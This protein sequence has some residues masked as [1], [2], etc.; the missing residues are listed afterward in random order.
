MTADDEAIALRDRVAR[1]LRAVPGCFHSELS[2]AGVP[3][4]D[5]CGAQSLIAAGVE[6]EVTDRLNSL[7]QLWDPD[8]QYLD[9]TFERFPE[10]FPDVRLIRPGWPE[11]LL[12]IEL[13]TWYLLSKEQEPAARFT[14]SVNACSERDLLAIYPWYWNHVI[15]GVPVLLAP[16]VKPAREVAEYRNEVWGERIQL[17]R[18]TPYPAPRSRYR[19]VPL[20]DPS[21]SA[22]GRIARCPGLMDDFVSNSLATDLCGIPAHYW[23]GFLSL[24]KEKAAREAIERGMARIAEE[25]GDDDIYVGAADASTIA[26]YLFAITR[27]LRD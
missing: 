20:L 3:A 7:R 22:W 8:G 2:L 24:F 6:R 11:P 12:G 16:W 5:L 26:D 15:T 14:A 23:V 1:A 18:T 4:T 21:A 13:K 19:D 27:I 25:V 17:A 10:S 9:C